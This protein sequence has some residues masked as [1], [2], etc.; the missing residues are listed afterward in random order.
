STWRKRLE[1]NRNRHRRR[2]R[3]VVAA[4]GMA[5]WVD[6]MARASLRRHQTRDRRTGLTRCYRSVLSDRRLVGRAQKTCHHDSSTRNSALDRLYGDSLVY[7]DLV[8]AEITVDPQHERAPEHTRQ[9]EQRVLHALRL[10]NPVS[11]ICPCACSFR[12]ANGCRAALA[13]DCQCCVGCDTEQ[14]R[15][16]PGFAAEVA[17]ALPRRRDCLLECVFGVVAIASDPQTYAPRWSAV[18]SEQL[19]ERV[20]VAVTNA[21]QKHGL[22]GVDRGKRLGCRVEPLCGEN[23]RDDWAT[24]RRQQLLYR[25]FALIGQRQS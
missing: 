22:S 5:R 1:R 6:P 13:N 12:A 20:L 15:R 18:T 2:A 17:D 11:G 14:P 3:H 24:L 10:G 4:V 8:V 23:P 25:G 7:R 21:P 16:E 19:D 9:F